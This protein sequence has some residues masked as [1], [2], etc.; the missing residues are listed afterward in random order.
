MLSVAKCIYNNEYGDRF[1]NYHLKED[2]DYIKEHEHLLL[3][4]SSD[5][6]A[7]LSF[8]ILIPASS[9]KDLKTLFVDIVRIFSG[10]SNKVEI[11]NENP[12]NALKLLQYKRDVLKLCKIFI[13]NY[14]IFINSVYPL[15]K[16]ELETY[17]NNL[18]AKLD[19]DKYFIYE[20]QD[21]LKL[22]YPY[23]EFKILISNAILNGPDG[24]DISKD[25]D[26][27]ATNDIEVESYLIKH[28]FIIYLFKNSFLT[29]K[30]YKSNKAWAYIEGLSEF[31]LEK[32]GV[33]NIISFK[34]CHEIVEQYKAMYDNNNEI[35]PKELIDTALKN[36]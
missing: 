1:R 7:L 31:Y 27:F 17:K 22:K 18:Q 21:L 32:L 5:E 13:A 14:D 12:P 24:L 2:L 23:D 26:V 29:L 11:I 20:A 4:T 3:K 34:Q 25:Q 16:D 33:K 36:K 8:L 6:E 15:I 9:D 10:H 28:E 19:E 30:R 35:T